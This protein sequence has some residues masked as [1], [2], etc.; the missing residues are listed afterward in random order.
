MYH[1]YHSLLLRIDSENFEIVQEDALSDH[2]PEVAVPEVEEPPRATE[3]QSL[4]LP[5]QVLLTT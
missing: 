1:I 2:T 3:D 4:G 5:L